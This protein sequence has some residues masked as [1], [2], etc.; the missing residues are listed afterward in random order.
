MR[1]FL[2]RTLDVV[3]RGQQLWMR[4]RGQTPEGIAEQRIVSGK[5]WEEYCDTLKAA[6][7]SLKFPGTPQD[8]FNQA[9][10]YRYLSRLVRAG[11][12]GFLEDSDPTV[13]VLKRVVHETVKMGA[14]NPD[15]FYQ[16]AGISGAYEY[17]IR[18]NRGTVAYLAFATQ[19]GHYG[20]GG[21]LPPTGALEASQLQMDPDGNFEIAV[22]CEKR[23][24]N[25]LPMKP[26]TGLLIVRQTFLDR[27]TEKLASLAIERVDGPADPAPVT[28]AMVDDGLRNASTLVVGASLLFAKWA[29]D[30]QK[31]SNQL[32]QFD[33]ATSNA[34]GGDPNI[35]YYHSHW[36]L[37][38]DEALVIDVMPPKCEYWNF[39]LNNYW[40]ESLEYRW[41]RIHTN[42]HLA[43]ANDDGS[44]RIVVAH[45][46]PGHPNWVQTV[47]HDQG[48]MCFRWVRADAHPVPRTRVVPVSRAASLPV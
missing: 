30:F 9:E 46:D 33:P 12:E 31:H 44:V 3:R 20:Q 16:N 28:P 25:W 23:A 7:A 47:G 45:T 48:T 15:N 39:Q 19:A 13:P 34:A 42:K 29:R 24:G 41:F 8:P 17:R 21:G 35:A 11:L 32:P 36:K 5:A 18:G 38:E 2:I 43:R 14:D 4:L 1:K 37:A 10:G 22:S 6:G 27:T 40:L 26:E